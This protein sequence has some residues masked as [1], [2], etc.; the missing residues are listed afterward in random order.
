M[1]SAIMGFTRTREDFV[2]RHCGQA[3]GGD[4]YTNHCPYCLWSRHVDVDPGDRAAECLGLMEP[5]EVVLEKDTYVLTHRCVACGHEKRNRAA[6]GDDRE[7]L[8]RLAASLAAR[9]SRSA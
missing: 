6:S 9:R 1:K 5:V 8:A 4:G 3:V 2:C 7:A